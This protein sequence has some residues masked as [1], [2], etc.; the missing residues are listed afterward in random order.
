VY[1]V[2]DTAPWGVKLRLTG[3]VKLNLYILASYT[4]LTCERQ[5]FDYPNA[6][7]SFLIRFST[8]ESYTLHAKRVK[9]V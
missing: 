8:R 2:E 3:A 1:S 7:L 9:N 4:A 5:A 6:L